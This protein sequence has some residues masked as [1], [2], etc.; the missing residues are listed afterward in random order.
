MIVFIVKALL[1]VL[2]YSNNPDIA[3]T[4]IAFVD[5]IVIYALF[6]HKRYLIEYMIYF[7]KS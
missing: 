5:A 3:M 7:S 6:N 4:Q 1:F 2:N